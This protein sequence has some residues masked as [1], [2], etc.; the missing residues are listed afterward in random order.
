MH[1][2]LAIA[3]A[4][5]EVDSLQAHSFPQESQPCLLGCQ[6]ELHGVHCKG[7]K[8][9]KAH[10][11]INEFNAIERVREAGSSPTRCSVSVLFTQNH[12]TLLKRCEWNTCTERALTFGME[13][14]VS[15]QNGQERLDFYILKLERG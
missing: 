6:W 14:G 1:G 9:S 10:D 12:L 8:A 15:R 2:R 4:H 7:Q 11:F 5:E 3:F 13:E